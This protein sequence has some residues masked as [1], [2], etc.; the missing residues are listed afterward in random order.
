MKIKSIVATAC[1]AALSATPVLAAPANSAAS[2]SVAKSVRTGSVSAKKNEL[3]G[4]GLIIALVAAAAVVAGIVIVA[5][6]D[7][8]SN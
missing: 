1:I 3:A 6:D 4:G 8:D 7:S 5:D 2:L